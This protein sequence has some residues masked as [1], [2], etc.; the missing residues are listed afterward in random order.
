MTSGA[1]A[2][3][4][5]LRA[6]IALTLLMAAFFAINDTFI[7]FL[8]GTFPVVVVL[9]AR[10]AMQ[11]V[12]IGAWMGWKA[13]Q[14]RGLS[15]FHTSSPRFQL[16]RGLLLLLNTTLG[17]ISLRV[18]P[19]AEFTALIMLA[20][21]V[22]TAIARVVLKEHVTAARWAMVFCGFVGVLL[23][24]K[25]GAGD[26]GW[27]ILVPLLMTFVFGTFQ[28]VTRRMS[29]SEDP[30]TTH[31][32]TGVVATLVLLAVGFATYSSILE[33]AAA[34]T[35]TQWLLLAVMAFFGCFGHMFMILAIG[36]VPISFF[37]SFA[38][39]QI[40]FA[41]LLGAVVFSQVPDAW[42][43]L[44]MVIIAA[45]GAIA[46]WLSLREA[47]RRND[48]VNVLAVEPLAD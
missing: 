1:P 7:K 36:K 17:I 10:Y 20:P 22:A 34:A 35:P 33:Q 8:G 24:I 41:T 38:Y 3:A 42:S 32:Y 29:V 27:P 30:F 39:S 21:L 6:G 48:R 47:A 28:V 11:F 13:V 15:N 37:T 25:P 26:L 23:I 45:A 44:G 31:F 4:A 14:S 16:L 2:N 5:N 19:L 43:A 40:A 18:L 9:L 12:T 46:L